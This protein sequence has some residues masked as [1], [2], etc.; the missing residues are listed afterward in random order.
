MKERN[1]YFEEALS[2]FVHDVASGGAIRHLVDLG[3]SVDQIME[4]LTY[5]EKRERVQ[6]SV[7]RY[8][9]ESRMI[10]YE[11]PEGFETYNIPP[12]SSAPRISEILYKKA[13]QY[14]QENCYISCPFG[15]GTEIPEGI[16][17]K[18]ERDYIDGIL[19]E[20]RMAY[21]QLSPRMREIGTKM[22]FNNIINGIIII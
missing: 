9:I 4:N 11:L 21:H 17:S 5:P 14:G 20:N 2:D 10:I 3:Y 12:G 16:L 7:I 18:R 22:I 8:M 19:W 6:R 13:E 1:H 15:M